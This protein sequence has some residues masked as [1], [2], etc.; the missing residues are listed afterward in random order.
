MLYKDTSYNKRGK[1]KGKKSVLH[2]G[3]SSS[4]FLLRF[5]FLALAVVGLV[6]LVVFGSLGGSSGGGTGQQPT[7][8]TQWSSERLN[9]HDKQVAVVGKDHKLVNNHA[10]L[11]FNYMSKRRVPNGPDPIHNRFVYLIST[12]KD[13]FCFVLFICAFLISIYVTDLYLDV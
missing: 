13:V 1:R 4:N 2:M 7:T 9:K 8:A 5:F 6:C 12:H 10:E 3:T 11:D